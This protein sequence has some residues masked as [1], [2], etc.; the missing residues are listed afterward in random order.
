[1]GIGIQRNSTRTGYKLRIYESVTHLKLNW[2]KIRVWREQAE[3]KSDYDN[4]DLH[5]TFVQLK[6][7]KIPP[8]KI[9][10]LLSHLERV[11]AVEITDEIT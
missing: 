11:S 5:A 3:F 8:Y 9:A 6:K 2:Y 4:K 7:D 10:E 1:M